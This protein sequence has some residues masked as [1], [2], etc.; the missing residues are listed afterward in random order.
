MVNIPERLTYSKR[1]RYI[2]Q[3]PNLHNLWRV[4]IKLFICGHFSDDDFILNSQEKAILKA[5][6]KKKKFDQETEIILS[7][8]CFSKLF[9]ANIRKKTK[10][11]LKFVFNKIFL[12]LKEKFRTQIFGMKRPSK[13]VFENKFYDWYFGK[14]SRT[15]GIPIKS[16]YLFQCSKREDSSEIPRSITKEFVNRIKMSESF[17]FDMECFLENHYF[18]FVISLNLKKIR[19][20]FERWEKEFVSNS[21]E[22][23]SKKI[24]L[25]ITKPG[26]KLPWTF[27]EIKYARELAIKSLK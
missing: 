20:I 26:N 13:S 21:L 8:N 18:N 24:I 16:F 6:V 19:T 22:N 3:F 17:V 2:S 23:A 7:K 5:I 12:F 1:N 9:S 11:S 27:S 4:I 15:L 10:D 14:V 25:G